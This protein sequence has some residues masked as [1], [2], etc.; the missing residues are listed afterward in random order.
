LDIDKTAQPPKT[1]C[2]VAAHNVT[3]CKTID[4]CEINACKK[5]SWGTKTTCLMCKKD[6]W[7]TDFDGDAMTYGN[8]TQSGTA[9]VINAEYYRSDDDT[10]KPYTCTGA[11]GQS[12][13]V[14]HNST[15]CVSATAIENCRRVTSTKADCAECVHTYYFD[16]NKCIL[17]G[18][19]MILFAFGLLAFMLT[20]F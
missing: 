19:L 6:Y 5:T 8:C 13:F 17:Q 7:P 1:T 9:P 14:N 3:A 16:G 11:G 12:Y 10:I 15:E 20:N 4:H 2:S 18:G